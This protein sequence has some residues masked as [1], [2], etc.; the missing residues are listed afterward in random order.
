MNMAP[1][2]Q[3]K[4]APVSQIAKVG[5]FDTRALKILIGMSPPYVFA[6]AD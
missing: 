2:A 6:F 5:F 4:N 1:A 3:M